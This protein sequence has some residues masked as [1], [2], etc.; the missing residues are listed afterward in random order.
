VGD[1][2]VQQK[3]YVSFI[4]LIVF[5]AAMFLNTPFTVKAE[6]AVIKPVLQM[7]T[8]PSIE[9]K[10]GGRISFSVTS[11]NYRGNVEYRVI[12]YNRTTKKTSELWKTPKTGYF[13]AGWRP[14]GNY[15]FVISWPATGMDPGAYS[16][17]VLVRRVG[18]RTPY[19]SYVKSSAF[20]IKPP[21][22]TTQN[23][24]GNTG[25]TAQ[26]NEGYKY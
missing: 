21:A 6:A 16:L 9:Y 13:Y 26:P 8:Q 10:P 17:T 7:I 15:K 22:P 23:S 3:K 2:A 11:P 5:I 4:S 24:T 19:D 18:I 14:A 25:T 12:L 20:W 1:D